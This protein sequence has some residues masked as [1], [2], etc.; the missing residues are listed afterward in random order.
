MPLLKESV[1]DLRRAIIDKNYPS[2]LIVRLELE[3][4]VAVLEIADPSGAVSPSSS[5]TGATALGDYL[6][7]DGTYV[8][9]P[10]S[11]VQTGTGTAVVRVVDWGVRPE[12]WKHLLDVSFLE[13]MA[14]AE[15]ML[16]EQ[17]GEIISIRAVYLRSREFHLQTATHSL[18]FDL[19]SP[20][21]DQIGRYRIFLQSVGKDA[22]RK[23]I[24]LRLQGRIVYL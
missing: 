15:Q 7:A 23:Y 16:N 19:R 8:T 1:P 14:Q 20:L 11:L 18:W 12:P 5:G 4:V 6:T 24:D 10:S 22:A 13:R 2:M 17:F 21:E 9:Y 3:P